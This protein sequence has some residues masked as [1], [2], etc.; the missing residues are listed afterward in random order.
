[1]L[2]HGVAHPASTGP[3]AAEIRRRDRKIEERNRARC[4]QYGVRHVEPVLLSA[5]FDRD[6]GQC[7]LCG[8]QVLLTPPTGAITLGTLGVPQ[9]I[10]HPELATL[11]HVV[12]LSER[13]DHSYA[14]V[15]LA[16]Q[17]CNA[18]TDR[19][20]PEVLRQLVQQIRARWEATARPPPTSSPAPATRPPAC[21][22]GTGSAAGFTW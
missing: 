17:V 4:R 6:G 5:V 10:P 8:G 18:R 19:P 22:P 13:G 14:N 20:P 11:D 1:M 2:E 21:G 9:A 7:W 12:P 15:L 3:A 16:H